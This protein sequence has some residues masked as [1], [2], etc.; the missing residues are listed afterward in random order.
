MSSEPPILHPLSVAD[1]RDLWILLRPWGRMNLNLAFF[2]V[3]YRPDLVRQWCEADRIPTP[4]V[5]VLAKIC[6]EIYG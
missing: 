6:G 5:I 1:E 2:L 4:N 3:R